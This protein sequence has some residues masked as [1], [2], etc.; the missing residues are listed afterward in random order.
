MTNSAYPF[1]RIT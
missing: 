1:L